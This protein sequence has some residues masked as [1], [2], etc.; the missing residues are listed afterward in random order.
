MGLAG[1]VV[2]IISTAAI[3]LLYRYNEEDVIQNNVRNNANN[4]ENARKSV[5]A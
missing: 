1:S 4:N 3:L 2:M 5:Y